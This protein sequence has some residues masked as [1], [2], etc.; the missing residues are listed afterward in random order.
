M[1]HLKAILLILLILGLSA[2]AG[3]PR[4]N[5]FWEDDNYFSRVDYDYW[6]TDNYLYDGYGI[7]DADFGW[8]TYDD[9]FDTWY[10]DVDDGYYAYD[11]YDDDEWFDWI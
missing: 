9:D 5:W 1:V 4:A 11:Y 8:D 10:G 7:Y 2:C 3:P 6:E